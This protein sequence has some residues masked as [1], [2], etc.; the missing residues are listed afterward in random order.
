MRSPLGKWRQNYRRQC[1]PARRDTRPGVT[2][3]MD[4]STPVAITAG[5]GLVRP[6][7]SRSPPRVQMTDFALRVQRI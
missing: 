6:R 4:C 3:Q 5:L 1:C 2:I 7:N